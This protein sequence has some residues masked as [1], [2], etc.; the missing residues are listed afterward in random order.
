MCVHLDRWDLT[1]QDGTG[2][3]GDWT[4]PLQASVLPRVKLALGSNGAVGKVNPGTLAEL[5]GD[6]FLVFADARLFFLEDDGHG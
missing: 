1:A 6:A 4:E 3:D 2:W 5:L